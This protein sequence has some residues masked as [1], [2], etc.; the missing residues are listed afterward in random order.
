MPELKIV[1]NATCTFCGVVCDHMELTV[2]NLPSRLS[3]GKNHV[4]QN[5]SLLPVPSP[6]L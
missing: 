4:S 1:E 2:K 6:G 3:L 5:C